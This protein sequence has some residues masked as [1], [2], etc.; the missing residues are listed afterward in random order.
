MTR[1]EPPSSGPNK[2]NIYTITKSKNIDIPWL[3]TVHVADANMRIYKM[4]NESLPWATLL[5]QSRY[6]S[7][8]SSYM[9]WAIPRTIFKGVWRKN[10]WHA[11]LK[12]NNYFNLRCQKYILYLQHSI[13]DEKFKWWKIKTA[14]LQ[15]KRR[16]LTA[17]F[18]YQFIYLFRLFIY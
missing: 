16:L 2:R 14:S 4:N 10:S 8:V 15:L 17:M 5:I 11:A 1:F 7:P 6:L 12:T 9:N 3:S 18:C 13:Q